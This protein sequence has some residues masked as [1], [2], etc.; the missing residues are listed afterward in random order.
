MD[1][2]G[3]FCVFPPTFGG[4]KV[5]VLLF[6]NLFLCARIRQRV[7]SAFGIFRREDEGIV[8]A[9]LVLISR[10]A[11]RSIHPIEHWPGYKIRSISV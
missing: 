3:A 7:R 8:S 10:V 6:D 1:S 11:S 4:Q 5:A 2:N 9:G